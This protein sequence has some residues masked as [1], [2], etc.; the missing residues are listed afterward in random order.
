MYLMLKFA[1]F[2]LFNALKCLLVVDARMDI[3]FKKNSVSIL[4][5]NTPGEGNLIINL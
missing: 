2:I 1:T 4:F 5:I 3:Q